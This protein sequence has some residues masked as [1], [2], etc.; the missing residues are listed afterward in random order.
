VQQ[1]G[2]PAH[3][4]PL[5][6]HERHHVLALGRERPIGRSA[7]RYV[8][9]RPVLGVVDGVPSEHQ[10]DPARHFRLL[11]EL[12]ECCQHAR[13]EPLATEVEQQALRVER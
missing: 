8:Q 7:Q 3:L 9:R 5:G 4:A 11:G 2:E 1:L 10:L 6:L 12:D 13:I